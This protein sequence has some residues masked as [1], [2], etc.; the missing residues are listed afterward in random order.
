MTTDV[1]KERRSAGR[2]VF[3]PLARLRVSRMSASVH[4]AMIEIERLR[5]AALIW[6]SWLAR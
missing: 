6:A 1:T 3:P 2:D 5:Q 4:A